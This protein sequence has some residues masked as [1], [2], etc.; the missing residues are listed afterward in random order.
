M[1][2]K[3][4]DLQDKISDLE[5]RLSDPQLVSDQKEYQKVV[6]E[7]SNLTRLN[8]KYLEYIKVQEDIEEYRMMLHDENEDQELKELAK[9][10]LEEL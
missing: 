6:R 5:G 7:H 4:S 2:E 3:F 8:E 9:A 10:E 1:F